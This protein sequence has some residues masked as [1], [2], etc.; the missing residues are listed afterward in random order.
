LAG[1]LE[2]LDEV[3]RRCPD[4]RD[5]VTA[6]AAISVRLGYIDRGVNYVESWLA[7]HPNDGA[8]REALDK[9]KDSRQNEQY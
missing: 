6:A 8:M 4:T 3:I 2:S 7:R 5:A 1:A 9:I